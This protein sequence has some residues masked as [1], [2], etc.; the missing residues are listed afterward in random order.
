[1]RS[2]KIDSI[3]RVPQHYD[4]ETQNI[5][6]R[7]NCSKPLFISNQISILS[8]NVRKD[9]RP[10][11]QIWKCFPINVWILICFAFIFI[12]IADKILSKNKNHYLKSIY[13]IFWVYFKPLIGIGEHLRYYSFFYILWLISVRPLTEIFRNDLLANLIAVPDRD[14]DNIDDLFVNDLD[15]Y[16]DR[17][18]LER[19]TDSGIF[20]TLLKNNDYQK[21]FEQLF[22]KTKSL[23]ILQKNWEELFD[24]TDKMKKLVM[25][26]VLIEDDQSIEY[27]KIFL[28]RF[29]SLHSGKESYIPKLI[30][31]LCY[32]P[33]FKFVKE[34]E[35]V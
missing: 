30:T 21:K 10:T 4:Y 29:I 8:A 1:V 2:G 15:V 18:K 27:F 5:Y 14:I 6:L 16:T 11:M 33:K 20:M 9:I 31:P 32:G 19:W 3:D 12:I 25:K 26:S 23:D 22:K 28:E 7:F 34:S 13:N 24:E 35:E 17:P